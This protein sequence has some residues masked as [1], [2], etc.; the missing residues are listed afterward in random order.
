MLKNL[1]LTTQLT[2]IFASFAT[3]LLLV[4]GGL[5]YFVGSLAVKTATFT[6]LWVLLG[7]TIFLIG[8]LLLICTLVVSF[9]LARIVTQPIHELQAG[10]ERVRQGEMDVRLPE[11][12]RNEL[13]DLARGFNAMA[14]ALAAKDSHLLAYTAGLEQK[15][16]ERTREL[17]DSEAELRALLL[18]MS[19]VILVVDREGRYL[20]IA[21]TSPNLLYRPADELIGKT[22][23]EV[24]PSEQAN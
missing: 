17:S 22:L 10:V 19:D 6:E 20:Q 13:G 14:A 18:A 8:L 3:G 1:R 16:Q 4:A 5:V 11:T 21:P 9:S 7:Q 23:A 24:F 15:V 2:I 12:A